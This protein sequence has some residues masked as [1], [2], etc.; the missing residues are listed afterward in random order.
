M[1]I[2]LNDKRIVKASGYTYC[3]NC[4]LNYIL[5][6]RFQSTCLAQDFK[7]QSKSKVCLRGYK[8]ETDV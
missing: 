8:Y 7:I 5:P 3:K 6:D 2:W 4:C 1:K